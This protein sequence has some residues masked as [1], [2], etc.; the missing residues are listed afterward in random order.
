[1]ARLGRGGFGEVWKA[2]GPGGVAVAL[3]FIRL[4]DKAGAVEQR[5]LDLIR[6]IRHPNLLALFGSWQRDG[7]LILALE[8]GEG[9]LLDRLKQA[10]AAGT[11]GIPAGELLEQMRDAARGLDYLNGRGIQHRD[12]KPHNFLLVGN[13]VKVADFGLAKLLQHTLSSNTGA[14]TP[15]YAAPEFFNGQTSSLSDQYSL[16]VTYCQL[17][18]GRLPFEGSPTELMMGH[19]IREPDLT[20]LPESE[21]PAVAR[22]LAKKP[23]ERWPSCREFVEALAV[24]IEDRMPR[25]PE[26]GRRTLADHRL[27]RRRRVRMAVV[28]GVLLVLLALPVGVVLWGLTQ[29]RQEPPKGNQ[30]QAEA[31][32]APEVAPVQPPVPKDEP[33]PKEALLPPPPPQPVLHLQ[34][35]TPMRLE[36]GESKAVAVH[37]GREHCKGPVEIYLAGLPT[38]VTA[39]PGV[40]PADA[41]EG[42]VELTAA[43]TADGAEGVVVRLEAR[44]ADASTQGTFR[45]TVVRRPP[46]V[47][48]LH[49]LPIAA[50]HLEAGQSQKVPVRIQREHCKGA[51]EL[52]VMGLPPG[53]AVPRPGL[54]P[55]NAEE[56]QVELA[57]AANA[58]AA[59]GVVRVEAVAA[60]ATAPGTFRLTVVRRPIEPAIK[61]KFERDKTFYQTMTTKTKQTMKVNDLD[62]GQNNEQTFVFSWTPKGQDDKNVFD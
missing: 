8:L 31:R 20:M 56:G 52:R 39:R 2:I 38:G 53:V 33:R 54:V 27:T 9:T 34:P 35:I 40:V 57:A 26:V 29:P 50:V 23:L 15:A 25:V 30:E 14:L 19:V 17:R 59:D 51:V 42:Q 37:I 55:A 21:R 28:L 46:P 24:G 60:D 18:G 58:E 49:L 36:A 45:L 13:G 41:E 11:V 48:A 6:N 22:A 10:Q 62:I 32:K 61:W 47:A 1:V 44:A 16:G 7:F 4:D 5:S 43:A 3:K 12:V